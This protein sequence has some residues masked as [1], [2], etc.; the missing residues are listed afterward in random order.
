MGGCGGIQPTG[1]VRRVTRHLAKTPRRRQ[2]FFPLSFF[3]FPCPTVTSPS[4]TAACLWPTAGNPFPTCF[5]PSAIAFYPRPT[6]L[7]PSPENS[8]PPPAAFSWEWANVLP[9][10][11][12][13]LR[14]SI[15]V[16]HG[17]TAVC[18][19]ENLGSSEKSSGDGRALCLI[20]L[21]A[22]R[23]ACRHNSILCPKKSINC[24]KK[25]PLFAGILT[26]SCAS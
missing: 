3:L 20:I 25:S 5:S 6:A 4:P 14:P 26:M 24:V 19:G 17:P 18:R 21:I 22:W 10:P 23:R 11:K 12:N 15:A 1:Q 13:A 9:A 7:L 2:A 8:F 16:Y